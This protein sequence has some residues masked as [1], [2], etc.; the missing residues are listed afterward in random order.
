MADRQYIIEVLLQ[1][2][3]DMARAFA[4]ATGELEAYDAELEKQ[5][6]KTD[7]AKASQA[8][9]AKS[10]TDGTKATD[11]HKDSIKALGDTYPQLRGKVKATADQENQ[12]VTALKNLEAAQQRVTNAQNRGLKGTTEYADATR[13]VTKAE[14]DLAS[15]L[16]STF[17][18]RVAKQRANEITQQI[19]LRQA[20]EQTI[21]TEAKLADQRD[22][23]AQKAARPAQVL[24]NPASSQRQELQ[25]AKELEAVQDQL[26][27]SGEKVADSKLRLQKIQKD[28][29]ESYGFE[30]KAMR[31]QEQILRSQTEALDRWTQARQRY[32]RQT[33]TPGD[34]DLL[35]NPITGRV[36]TQAPA[37][38]QADLAPAL[39]NLQQQFGNLN[40]SAAGFD[41]HVRNTFGVVLTTAVQ[42]FASLLLGLV[43]TYGSL[44][45]AAVAAGTAIGTTFASA[46]AQSVPALGLMGA[47]M[48]RLQ[49]VMGLVT[50]EA[51]LQQ[52]QFIAQYQAAYQNALGIN[53]VTIAQHS[54]SDALYAVQQAVWN[55]RTSELGLLTARQQATRQLQELIFQEESARLAAE[56]SS[57]A[58]TNAQKALQ[59]AIATGGD[60]Q[61]AQL[62][63]A[64]AHVQHQQSVVAAQ[65]AIT[66]A[67][68]GSLARQNIQQQVVEAQRAVV[69]AQRAVVDAQFAATQA[70]AAVIQAQQAQQGFNIATAAQLAYLRSQMTATELSLSQN[71]LKIFELFRGAHGILTPLTNAILAPFVGIT[72]Q[73]YSLLHD[74]RIIG[75][76]QELADAIGS[77]IKQ[78]SGVFLNQQGVNTFIALTKAAAQNMK[79]L[80]EIVTG[81][82]KAFGSIIVTAIP[83]VHQFANFI[84]GLVKQ[85]S[86]WATSQS[87]KNWLRDWFTIAF[88]SLK[89]FI[90]L[91][92]A[93]AK[94]IAAIIGVGGGAKSG[95]GI[96]NDLTSSIDRATKS[97]TTH[98]KIW[99]DLQ[100]LWSAALPA[101]KA[102]HTILDAVG[103][104][105]LKLGGSKQ[106]QNSLQ[107]LADL[108]AHVL[109]PAFVK[110]AE[111]MGKAISDLTKFLAKHPEL[112]S[113]L[114]DLIAFSLTA[115]VGFRAIGV[116]LG[117]LFTIINIFTH[118][119][120]VIG[121]VGDLLDALPEGFLA[122]AGPIGIV[123]GAIV[124]ISA[125]THNMGKLINEVISP[126]KLAWK[127]ISDALKPL[128]KEIDQLGK[129]IGINLSSAHTDVSAFL[130]VL[131]IALR[132]LITVF[133]TPL[134]EGIDGVIQIVKTFIGII[135]SVISVFRGVFDVIK[136]IVTGNGKEI[137]KGFEE[138]GKGILE[139]IKTAVLAIPDL[140]IS[141]FKSMIKDVENFLGIS[142]PSKKFKSIG[143]S[144]VDG[145]ISVVT[146]LPSLFLKLGENLVKALIKGIGNLASDAGKAFLN[147]IPSPIRSIVGGAISAGKSVVS[148][149]GNFFGGLAAGGPIPGYGGGDRHPYLLEGG[150]HVF[151]KEEVRG[152]GGH[153]AIFSLRRML[154]GGT[155]GGPFG[156]A[157]GGAVAGR[158]SGSTA[159]ALIGSGITQTGQ[160]GQIAS[161]IK[162][163]TDDW[164]YFWQTITN[165]NNENLKDQFQSF[166]NNFKQILNQLTAFTTQFNNQS[167]NFWQQANNYTQNQLQDLFDNFKQTYTKVDTDTFNAFWYIA[168]AANTSLKAF[169]AKPSPV[170]LGAIPSFAGGGFIG[171]MGER[172]RDLVHAVLGRGE[173]VLNYAHQKVVDP[174]LRMV[175]GWGLGEMFNKVRGTHAGPGSGQPNEFAAG[176]FVMNDESHLAR[177]IN[178]ANQVSNAHFPYVYGGG[179]E[180]PAKFQPFDCSGSVSYVTQQAGYKVP[181][182]VS[183]DMGSWGFPSGSGEV[184]IFY[185]PVH[186]FMRIMGRYFGTSGF[187]RNI[188]PQSDWGGAGWFT[189]AP[190][191][192][193][194]S[195]FKTIHLTDLG[196]AGTA[197]PE[198]AGSGAGFGNGGQQIETLAVKGDGVMARV[199][200]AAISKVTHAANSFISAVAPEGSGGSGQW[201]DVSQ[202]TTKAS[203]YGAALRWT[204]EAMR[205]AGVSG[206][207]WQQMLMRQ[208]YRESTYRPNAVNNWDINAAH[209][210]PSEGI[211]QT[212]LSTF[213]QYALPGYKN[214]LNPID[215]IVAA[216]RYMIATYG[217]GNAGTA[218]QVMWDRGGGAYAGGGFVGRAIP[219]LA[220]AGEWVVNQAQQ[221][222]LAR[223]LGTT[224]GALKNSMGFTGGPTSFAGGGEV[225][226]PNSP[227]P[228]AGKT[229]SYTLPNI[230]VDLPSFYGAALNVYNQAQRITLNMKGNNS[231]IEKGLNQFLANFNL[232][233]G[234][235][236][237]FALAAQAIQDFTTQETAVVQ[238]A[239]AGVRVINNTLRSGPIQTAVQ[240]AQTDLNSTNLEISDITKLQNEQEIALRN[241]DTELKKL[242]KPNAKNLKQYQQLVAA[243]QNLINDINAQD[244]NLAQA[245][246]DKYNKEVALFQ[247]QVAQT[248]RG[249]GTLSGS[250]VASVSGVA[251]PNAVQQSINNLQ[252]VLAKVGPSIGSGLASMAQTIA[253]T[254]GN[255]QQLQA[256]DAAV[257]QEAQQTQTDL[258]AA[259]TAAAAKAKK[260][261]RWQS[262]ADDLLSQ[263][264]SATTAVAQAQAQAL[265]DAITAVQN[266]AQVQQAG[267]TLQNTLSQVLAATSS[268]FGPLNQYAA[269]TQ[270]IATSQ[271]NAS[272]LQG[273]IASYGG[274]NVNA[275]QITVGNYSSVDPNSLLGQAL[276]QGNTGAVQQLV[277]S[278]DDL[279]GQM[280]QA[281]LQTQ[282][283]ITQYQQL[284]VTLLDTQTQATSGFISA[285]TSISQTIGQILGNQ[286]LPALISAAQGLAQDLVASGQQAVGNI[287][288]AIGSSAFGVAGGQANSLLAQA[289]NAFNS[290]PQSY[291]NWLA[292]MAPQLAAFASGLPQDQQSLFNG[293]IQ[294]LTDNT[295]ATVSNTLNLQE[296][297]ATTNQQQF[298]SSAWTMFRQAIFNGIGG[299][300]PSYAMEVPSLDVGG[301]LTSNG[302]LY[303]HKNEL[304]VPASVA[305]GKTVPAG[306]TNHEHHWH[307]T[308]PTEVAD[309]VYLG[310]AVAWR[311]NHD[312]NS[313]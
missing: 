166:Q 143:Q 88:D 111:N 103:D 158:A 153:G 170:S 42:P 308:N 171:N 64:Q 172:G 257:L 274:A 271:N 286:N 261:P 269:I 3:D 182:T 283:L 161:F 123:V 169:G 105:F 280:A 48:Q 258:Q 262:V 33:A 250:D 266:S 263:L 7:A 77:V 232:V 92:L 97:I 242:G 11:R 212:T 167:T 83:Y 237:L 187:A 21:A 134:I 185:N 181:T 9:Y 100:S 186:T 96:L 234:D 214:I 72:S 117:P 5:K 216:I 58:V 254:F 120:G 130:T 193:Y 243:R 209:G 57:L 73:I 17:S 148:S 44:A 253:Q 136:G 222:G 23:I 204:K 135:Q 285:S 26:V 112:E 80:A 282:Q 157:A 38:L 188:G 18:D 91:G 208:E 71:I 61:S 47:A 145:I 155:Q 244:Q 179:H 131:G 268:I 233:G 115:S 217:H 273:Q 149:I 246:T 128:G 20:T 228:E 245:L 56:A 106:G 236:G 312:P 4:Q 231:K 183:G 309:P 299:L 198:G 290:G 226:G 141:V 87:G 85:F 125:A 126:F 54:Y 104:A 174:A 14:Q 137:K 305:K 121:A 191:A 313:R 267:V 301:M 129:T 300:L 2:R 89:K 37:G 210:D 206:A 293:L 298:T 146:S 281:N 220:H 118:L 107:G 264:E 32:A 270:Q 79:P 78:V 292:A 144:I 95:I 114:K 138:I 272:A 133:I 127:D 229:G 238:L 252:G 52:Q 22:R 291:A 59:A 102:L 200:K 13:G 25:A 287:T 162:L 225:G 62:Q 215:N 50:G 223:R 94:L 63:V 202:A 180:Q 189:E 1:A 30:N 296:L 160:I 74:P 29:Y 218:A 81:L 178:A 8:E 201:G 219:I 84:A 207:L 60:V 99:H 302:L 265:S 192:A 239:A 311:L 12:R 249:V 82:F 109:V 154:G 68:R 194:L 251:N 66:D 205:L 119:K 235:N 27:A 277:Q 90:D 279:T 303:G 43:G 159:G 93:F 147:L 41:Q 45:S 34:R 227:I 241:V 10:L 69:Q 276:A 40:N 211:L 294:A 65:N 16:R 289:V 46:V 164:V 140:I 310:N 36:S 75:A 278:I 221:G 28:A 173:A 101:L 307:L 306:V 256:A 19:A 152:A 259:Y 35:T 196:S 175:Y 203:G 248:L 288:S 197:V 163:Y 184:T 176:G 168:H 31:D 122:V 142:S 177:L 139:G 284:S 150:E 199:L 53:Q 51:A 132:L 110:F 195:N 247:A 260:D 113:M 55:V 15:T 224:V 304:I 213:G 230:T 275:A 49:N 6:T 86:D 39:S 240:Q 24:A 124:A 116:L 76:L 156:F 165:L 108:I 295:T 190:G 297:N 98:G 255:P 151:T 70:R 67:A